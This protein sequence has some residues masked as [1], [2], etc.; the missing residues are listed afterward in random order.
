MTI[1]NYI[2]HTLLHPTATILDIEKLCKEAVTHHFFS[3]CVNGSFVTQAHQFLQHSNVKVCSVVGFPL[4]AMYTKAKIF[5]AEQAIKN[6]A[7]EIDVVANLGWLASNNFK[8]AL[9]EL[10]ILKKTIG[11]TLLK[12]IIETCYLTDNQK[13]EA[14]KIVID[15]GAE[16]VKTSTGFGTGGATIHDVVLLKNV[17]KNHIQI[18]ASGGIRDIET[19]KK[20]IELGVSRIGT[21]NG[22]TIVTDQGNTANY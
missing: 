6:G 10:S 11:N 20:Y 16:Y 19:A 7:H 15:S 18:K 17:A 2:D 13:E 4:G 14:C 8:S 12:V 9:Q 5:E 3:V 22:V 21:S 1:N